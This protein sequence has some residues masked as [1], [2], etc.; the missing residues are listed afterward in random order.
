MRTST[1]IAWNTIAIWT[2]SIVSGLASLV[3][4]RLLVESLDT[5][6]FGLTGVLVGTIGL[7]LMLD[8]GLRQAVTRHLAKFIALAEPARVNQ[9][10]SSGLAC[11]TA[12]GAVFA[13]GFIVLAPWIAEVFRLVPR[14]EAIMLLRTYGS[15]S[16][17][18]SFIYPTYEAVIVGA[19]R[20]D[21]N[22]A[23]K[24]AEVIVRGV[25]V[26]VL[27][28]GCDL[29]L[30][31]WAAARISGQLARTLAN[32]YAAHRLWPALSARPALVR[33]D[34][35]GDLFRLGGWLSVY[36]LVANLNQRVD[37]LVIARVL[38]EGAGQI[39]TAAYVP[40]SA[41]AYAVRP[42][43]NAVSA[44][45]FTLATG[46]HETDN[47]A[48][49]CALLLR[50][51]RVTLLLGI[52]NCVIFGCLADRIIHFWLGAKF[53][54]ASATAAALVIM[55]ITDVFRYSGK[56]THWNV[57]LGMDRARPIVVLE[58]VVA[59][60]NTVAAVLMV[61]WMWQN[62][63]GTMS[64]TGT[65][66]PAAVTAA[67]SRALIIVYVARQTEI[68]VGHYLRVSYVAPYVLLLAMTAT[69]LL[70]RRA[71]EPETLPRL[72]VCI[73]VPLIVWAAG[74]W[75]WAFDDQDRAQLTRMF[76]RLLVKLGRHRQ[77]PPPDGTNDGGAHADSPDAD[78]AD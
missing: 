69:A 28:V 53:A 68:G 54:G 67:I 71:V 51:T 61:R 20:F 62:G 35:L 19:R 4:V 60:I 45:I 44:Q 33:R 64:I 2:G 13:L 59:A 11:Y 74:C 17:I 31:G 8:L 18:L 30:Y 34:A 10:L 23:I 26:L 41:L 25:A 57:M 3:I 63:W 39:A 37:P 73:A 70:T 48:H 72:A 55:S 40:A 43:V 12:I 21:V 16:A 27:V 7:S 66:L 5:S 52:P 36:Q 47:R 24:S 77:T 50:G 49:L 76:G 15:I 42:F 29:G 58:L 65:L 9:V 75:W 32:V 56:M 38:G 46:Y 22:S 78:P 14:Q 6:E 1:L